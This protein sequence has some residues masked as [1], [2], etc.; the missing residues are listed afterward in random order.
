MHIKIFHDK[1]TGQSWNVRLVRRGERYGLNNDITHNEDDP[2]VEFFDTRNEHTN[3]G[4]FVSRY[5]RSTLLES[6]EG[7]LCLQGGEPRWNIQSN[8]MA[9]IRKWLKE[10]SQEKQNI[11]PVAYWDSQV[12]GNGM[13]E[14]ENGK[15]FLMEFID[16]RETSGQCNVDVASADG[17]LDDLMCTTFEINRLPGSDEET[18]CLHLHFDA[19]NLAASFFKQGDKFIILPETNVSIRDTVLPSGER[20]WI[21]E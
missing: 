21:L 6:E 14:P 2:L 5:F 8:C 17:D 13:G 10:A 11:V 18:Q 7:G 19:D 12:Y 15:P 16:R 9:R 3:L 1:D 4:Q 20:G